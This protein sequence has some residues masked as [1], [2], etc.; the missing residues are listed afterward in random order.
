MTFLH[1][2]WR[3][4]VLPAVLSIACAFGQESSPA[5]TSGSVQNPVEAAPPAAAAVTPTPDT[6]AD[7]EPPGGNRVFGVLPNFRTA[8][9][10]LEGTVISARAKLNIARKDS[11]DYP[12]VGLSAVLAGISQ[13]SDQSPSFGQGMKGYGHRLLTNYADQA[14]GNMLTEGVFPALLHE[15]PRY[16]RRGTGGVWKRAFYAASRVVITDKDGGGK[17][18]NYSEWVG[19]SIA[20][21]VSN[22]YYPDGRSASDNAAKLLQ[23]CGTDALSQVLK[24]FWPDIKRKLVH[25]GSD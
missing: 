16:F 3:A 11:F 10:S 8:D 25:K 18:F 24:E 2:R 19:N 17:R 15:D 6:P 22:A 14:I 23:Q 1:C 13:W 7:A 21:A 5:Q 4:L 12:L 9:A 20:V